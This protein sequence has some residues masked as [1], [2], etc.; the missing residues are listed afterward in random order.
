PGRMRDG[1]GQRAGVEPPAVCR[2]EEGVVCAARER[3]PSLAQVAREPMRRL[4][5]ERHDPVLAALAVANVYVL[6]LEVEV[7]E[8][9][10]DRLGAAQACGVHELD[11]RAVPQRK[12]AVAFERGE[13]LVDV[14][15]ARGVGQTAASARG[16]PRV[17]NAGSAECVTEER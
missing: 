3:R 14:G 13:L 15:A 16:E 6:L 11:E 8:V 17:G 9:E 1:P 2:N 4:L 12:R 7:D 10:P 5:A